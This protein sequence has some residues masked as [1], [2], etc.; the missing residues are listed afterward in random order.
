METQKILETDE[1]KLLKS[2]I[3]KNQA[4]FKQLL[5]VQRGLIK[6]AK[7]ADHLRIMSWSVV[8]DYKKIKSGVPRNQHSWLTGRY[9]IAYAVYGL[10][11]VD[12]I[13]GLDKYAFTYHPSSNVQIEL[14]QSAQLSNWI[15]ICEK[16]AKKTEQQFYSI[17]KLCEQVIFEVAALQN[18]P[19]V[20]WANWAGRE[21][22][23]RYCKNFLKRT[24]LNPWNL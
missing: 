21:N 4:L 14:T 17:Y 24:W 10:L 1:S 5:N 18:V 23:A 9:Q 3:R 8:C 20:V 6:F 19:P 22:W 7:I 2:L 13:A 16:A 12:E 11:Y 15:T